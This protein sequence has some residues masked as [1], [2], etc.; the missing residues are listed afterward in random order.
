MKRPAPIVIRDSHTRK[1]REIVFAKF[2]PGQLPEAASL[3]AGL[4]RLTVTELPHRRA[5][6]IEYDLLDYTMQ[7]LEEGLTEQGFHLDNT[8]MCKLL[9]AFAYYIEETQ[10]HNL[11][12]PERLI[13][14]YSKEAYAKAWDNHLHGDHDDTPAEWREYK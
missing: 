14:T 10:L 12:A 8:L 11:R 4:E 5:L 7:G 13:K 6:L 2:P 9:R 1:Q 3:L